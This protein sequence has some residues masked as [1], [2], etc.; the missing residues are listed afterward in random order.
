MTDTLMRGRT[1]FESRS[2]LA[3]FAQ[4]SAADSEGSLAVEKLEQLAICAYMVGRDDKCAIAWMRAHQEYMHR[5][6]VRRAARCAFWQ[7]SG[8]LF[9][10]ELAPAMGWIARGRRVLEAA[11]QDCV[12]RGWL[13]LLTALP[14]MFEGD[15]VSAYH[16]FA[17]ADEIAGA[18]RRSR[19]RD[20]RPA[21]ARA[22]P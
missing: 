16:A 7:A 5:G 14:V 3:E 20:V 17:R 12:E 21:A 19:S 2:W 22:C 18:L 6:E 1:P 11:P 8:L 10:G 4:L 13:L 15:A 9:R